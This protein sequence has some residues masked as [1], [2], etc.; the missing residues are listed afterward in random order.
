LVSNVYK[1]AQTT[2]ALR[3]MYPEQSSELQF[4]NPALAAFANAIRNCASAAEVCIVLNE[5]AAKAP[6]LEQEADTA[7]LQK[8]FE[9][10]K[11]WPPKRPP[12][13]TPATYRVIYSDGV[14]QETR[15]IPSEIE[16]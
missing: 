15:L 16:K 13:M 7:A 4:K 1:N 12:E 6:L 3:M 2:L 14:T 9:A 11:N 10:A 5:A 8:A